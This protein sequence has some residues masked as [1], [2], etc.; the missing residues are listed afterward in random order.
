M[1]SHRAGVVAQR[2]DALLGARAFLVAAGAAER[3][4]EAVLGDGVE[5]RPRLEPVA[6]GARPRLLDHAAGVD[7]RLH[8]GDDERLAELRDAPVA[9]LEH[10]GEVVA[11]VD[12]QQRER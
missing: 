1:G 4:V 10:L 2:E 6:R 3:R 11:G 8:A 7:R 9:E 12:V 5:Q